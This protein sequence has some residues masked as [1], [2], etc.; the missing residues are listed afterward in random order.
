MQKIYYLYSVYSIHSID[1]IKQKIEIDNKK[2]QEYE[3][4]KQSMQNHSNSSFNILLRDNDKNI[5]FTYEF[6][7][8]MKVIT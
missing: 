4:Q 6:N 7:L 3:K 1:N 5:I 2:I 8:K